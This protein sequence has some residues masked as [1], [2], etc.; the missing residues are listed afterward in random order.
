MRT[1]YLLLV[2]VLLGGCSSFRSYTEIGPLMP[3]EE[4]KEQ[5]EDLD[6]FLRH[7]FTD[8]AYEALK[9][10]P[11]IDGPSVT[12]YAAG[13]NFWSNAVSLFTLNGVGRK[14]VCS[15]EHLSQ[16]GKEILLHEYLHHL[17]DLTR[18]GDGDFIDLNEFEE[19]YKRM[20]K[21]KLW[22][23]VVI[24]SEVLSNNW[25]TLNFGIG[26]LSEP[27]AYSGSKIVTLG[28]PDYFIRVF[29]KVFRK[30]EDW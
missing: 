25:W 26:H 1:I 19:A 15:K 28:G 30:Y 23:G 4:R 20:A 11:L 14:V 2:C 29:R 5:S 3:K 6:S 22:A 9:D 24:Y 7:H 21:D 10:I 16:M 12:P 18:D 27:I 13:V 8:K 17:D